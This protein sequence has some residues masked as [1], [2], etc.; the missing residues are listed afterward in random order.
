V[1]FGRI[2]AGLRGWQDRLGNLTDAERAR[3]GLHP[4]F[5]EVPAEDLLERFVVGHTEDH[6]AQLRAILAPTDG[7]PA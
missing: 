4:R 2:D 5:G 3:P 6:V 1:L 7:D